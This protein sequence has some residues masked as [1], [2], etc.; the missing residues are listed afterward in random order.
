[1]LNILNLK[2][3]K[4]YKIKKV[5]NKNITLKQKKF[6]PNLKNWKNSIYVYN[7]KILSNIPEASRLT[8]ELI[9][10]YFNLF[11]LNLEKLIKDNQIGTNFRKRSDSLS[12]IWVTDGQFKHTNDLLDITI[13]F[14]NKEYLKYLN[15]LPNKYQ[16]LSEYY[17]NKK[18]LY[19]KET[20]LSYLIQQRKLKNLLLDK[21]LDLN[22]LDFKFY[23]YKDHM[24]ISLAKE[25]EY[26]NLKQLIFINKYKFNNY[27]LQYL[28]NLLKK[29]YKKDI[30]FNF[31]N[32]KYFYMSSHLF[33]ENL[34]LR[35]KNDRANLNRYLRSALKS[36]KVQKESLLQN[37]DSYLK[38][39]VLKS[40][41]YKNV[42][43]VR[44]E[45]TGRLTKRYAAAR[46][47]SK[48]YF[49]GSLRNLNSSKNRIPVALIRGKFKPNLDY[50]N[51]NSHTRIGSFGI[52]GWIAG[53]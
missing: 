46:S 9:R 11:S 23:D 47:L 14:D 10:G 6:V 34:I 40:I 2:L 18:L 13:F 39:I 26:M 32:V 44:I 4:N 29:L 36:V 50:T 20:S 5:N 42:S 51:L 8:N 45:A 28:T 15:V 12:K 21:K 22:N 33:T 35:I 37:R 19:L 3:K 52:K 16:F 27:Y 31:I 43:G 7:K 38:E 41:E 17:L 1:M 53:V 30:R 25:I 48:L 49:S 24:K